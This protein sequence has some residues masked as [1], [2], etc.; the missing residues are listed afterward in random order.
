MYICD[1]IREERTKEPSFGA[2][3]ATLLELVIGTINWCE[4]IPDFNVCPAS[5][6]V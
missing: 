2:P 5:D 6:C 1:K 3:F 4:N